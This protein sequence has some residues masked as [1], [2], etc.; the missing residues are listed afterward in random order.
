MLG[1]EKWQIC[2]KYYLPLYAIYA[3]LYAFAV[4]LEVQISS[5]SFQSHMDP[6]GVV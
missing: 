4:A 5:F 1:A 6:D 3:K 2:A